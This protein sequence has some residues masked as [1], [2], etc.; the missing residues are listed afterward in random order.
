MILKWVAE[1]AILSI[2]IS[3]LLHLFVVIL[4]FLLLLL[5]TTTCVSACRLIKAEKKQHFLT[6]F[7]LFFLLQF[8][9]NDRHETL[10]QQDPDCFTVRITRTY[11]T[12]GIIIMCHC[13]LASS[14]SSSS[15][16]S[17]VQQLVYLFNL[18]SSSLIQ[19]PTCCCS[20]NSS[21]KSE[22]MMAGNIWPRREREG[23]ENSLLLRFLPSFSNFQP[24][25]Q[26]LIN[27]KRGNASNSKK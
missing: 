21:R 1:N 5:V 8:V 26:C 20:T 3:P 25:V 2:F 10:C 19:C 7:L 11:S 13:Y 14:S 9:R 4:F 6:H 12:P 17:S 22:L 15:S 23:K 24:L 18:L 27:R 16:A